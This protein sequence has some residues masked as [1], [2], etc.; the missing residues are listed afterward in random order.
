[1]SE[2][3]YFCFAS[4]A[5]TLQ[6]KF[7]VRPSDTEIVNLLLEFVIVEGGVKKGQKVVGQSDEAY[8]IDS[9]K[10]NKLMNRKVGLYSGLKLAARDPKVIDVSQGY[11]SRKV[12]PRID[13]QQYDNVIQEIR[14]LIQQDHIA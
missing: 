13:P 3:P 5:R 9:D 14:E 12:I 4:F 8:N 6:G 10:A 7:M 11:F 1:M 2:I